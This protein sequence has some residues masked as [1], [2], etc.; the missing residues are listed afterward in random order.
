MTYWLLIIGTW[1]AGDY[2]TFP[3]KIMLFKTEQSCNAI[4]EAYIAN[5]H[6][7]NVVHCA[8]IENFNQDDLV[9]KN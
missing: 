1:M 5:T 4:R 6:W 7:D 9:I 8:K 2:T 3:Q